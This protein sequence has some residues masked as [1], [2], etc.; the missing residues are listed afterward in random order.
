MG[1]KT[2]L[3]GIP[4]GPTCYSVNFKHVLQLKNPTKSFLAD[5]LFQNLGAQQMN[6]HESSQI[7][8]TPAFKR[9]YHGAR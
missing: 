9:R 8:C 5:S 3:T 7:L 6:P 2:E 4:I 1:K